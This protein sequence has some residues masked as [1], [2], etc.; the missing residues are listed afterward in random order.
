M[1]RHSRKLREDARLLYLTNEG[2]SVSEIA[3]RLKVKPHTV[4][5]WKKDEDWEGLR[6]KI[7]RQAAE[8]LV[9]QLANERVTLN[10]QHFKFWSVVSS[11][12][13]ESVQKPGLS[14]EEVRSLERIAAILEKTQRG[15]RLARG[16]SLDGQ[17]EEQI[18]AE[19]LSA[20]RHIVDIVI[21]TVKREV[22]DPAARDRIVRVLLERLHDDADETGVA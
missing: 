17:T 8:K 14:T 16:L 10:A 12:L 7:D 3:R 9:E 11:R 20:Q 18:R 21:E 13:L 1:A 4:G 19:M 6:F 2:L 5:L 15:Q 22:P